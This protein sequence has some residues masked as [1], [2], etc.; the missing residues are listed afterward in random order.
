VILKLNSLLSFGR[1][2]TLGVL[3]SIGTPV[4]GSAGNSVKKVKWRPTGNPPVIRV[5]QTNG[6][7][8]DMKGTVRFHIAL[9]ES[10]RVGREVETAFMALGA[11]KIVG[12]FLEASTGHA[13]YLRRD[14]G[15]WIQRSTFDVPTSL[16][17]AAATCRRRARES[18]DEK[19]FRRSLQLPISIKR[20]VSYVVQC[21][22]DNDD[23]GKSTGGI[24]YVVVCEAPGQA[25]KPA[26]S[27]SHTKPI[28]NSGD[29]PT[30][31]A[32]RTARVHP[33]EDAKP[34]VHYRDPSKKPTPK[35]RYRDASEA[36][37]PQRVK[38][39][40]VRVAARPDLVISQALPVPGEP[41]RL[42]IQIA[43]QGSGDAGPTNLK[44]YYHR[45]GKRIVRGAS[46]PR[47]AAGE[48]T[49]VVLELP[50]SSTGAEHL[51]LSVDDP[52]RIDEGDEG[53]NGFAFE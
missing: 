8:A 30:G 38:A 12:G 17:G 37:E 7:Y 18:G 53:N 28:P 31:G 15:R 48:S 25:S 46:V 36:S 22:H 51:G 21:G 6:D 52:N 27:G 35:V 43:N 13:Q 16:L 1:L 19:A 24:P 4:P 32:D 40:A 10:C 42:R 20:D 33:R 26:S 2:A 14:A 29:S 11:P 23:W 44:A 5:I 45:S 34:K 9:E 41:S 47:L 49:W 50:G 3:L 39:A